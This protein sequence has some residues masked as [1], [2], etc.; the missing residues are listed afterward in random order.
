MVA[1]D[2]LTDVPSTVIT[3]WLPRRSATTVCHAPS[4]TRGFE[5]RTTL[6][7]PS[8]STQRSLPIVEPLPASS[9]FQNPPGSLA[10][11]FWTMLYEAPDAVG[12]RPDSGARRL[13]DDRD[14]DVAGPRIQDVRRIGHGDGTRRRRYLPA[15]VASGIHVAR[16]AGEEVPLVTT[17]ELH[18]RADCTVEMGTRDVGHHR[19]ARFVHRPTADHSA[20]GRRRGGCERGQRDRRRPNDEQACDVPCALGGAH[21][22]PSCT[23]TRL[24]TTSFSTSATGFSRAAVER[25]T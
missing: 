10:R 18:G 21:V 16:P 15:Q 23:P 12:R 3:I 8:D 4:S 22:G 9:S 17:T 6:S 13:E 19:P 1:A 14:R 25:C 7:V 24:R 2:L 11:A 20:S 5:V